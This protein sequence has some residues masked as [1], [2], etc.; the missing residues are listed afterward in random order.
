[1]AKK[2]KVS[3]HFRSMAGF[4]LI[5]LMVTIAILS[6]LTAISIPNYALYRAK[7]ERAN[8]LATLKY[9]MDGEDFYFAENGQFFPSRG[10]L[11]IPEGKA[12]EIPELAYHFSEGHKNRFR[13]RGTNN[14]NR[15]RYVI[16]AFCDFDSNGNGRDDRFRAIT[17]IRRGNVVR[18][19]EIVQTR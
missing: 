18:N 8:V 16:T 6:V 2:T 7:A 1:M 14:R 15:N 9:L 13:I 12:V 10:N 19:R 4:T 5:E 11:N 17:D 3:L